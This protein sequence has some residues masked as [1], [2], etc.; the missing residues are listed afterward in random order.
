M[1]IKT[2][3]DRAGKIFKI[4]KKQYPDAKTALDHG[5]PFELL[6]ATILS[7][8]CTDERVNI[9]TKDLFRKYRGPADYANASLS[10]LEED[11]RSTGFFRQKA[12]NIQNACRMIQDE[13]N[14]KLPENL[15]DMIK[16]PG[17]ARKTANIVLGSGLG[18]ITGIAVDTH[19]K[20][21][22]ERLGFSTNTDPDKIEQ[23]LMRLFP[24]KNWILIS[25]LLILHGRSICKARKP[26]C[27]TCPVSDLCP[28]STD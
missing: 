15:A 6:I 28:S 5:S 1:S 8:Q 12:K 25:Q 13:F 11:I 9:V 10:E 20:R 14:G 7:A 17:V 19:V 23:D 18:I 26:D 16:L 3:V 24:E 4:L 2:E 21:L 27:A 22:S